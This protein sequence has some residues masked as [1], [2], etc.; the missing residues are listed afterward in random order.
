MIKQFFGKTA[1]FPERLPDSVPQSAII[2]S[3]RVGFSNDMVIF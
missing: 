1:S 3:F 2:Y